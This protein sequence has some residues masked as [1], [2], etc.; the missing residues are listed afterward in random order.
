MVLITFNKVV[1][2][3]F[4]SFKP[5][6]VVGGIFFAVAKTMRFKIS[7]VYQIQTVFIT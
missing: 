3:V 1:F 2:P 7:F 5:F 4:V 6:F